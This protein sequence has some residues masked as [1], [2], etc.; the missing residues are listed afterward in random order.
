MARDTPATVAGIKTW[1]RSKNMHVVPIDQ[2]NQRRVDC[3]YHSFVMGLRNRTVWD[4]WKAQRVNLGDFC[5]VEDMREQT[6][7]TLYQIYFGHEEG[8]NP[9]DVHPFRDG[10]LRHVKVCDTC[11]TQG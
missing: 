2:V 8:L 9:N 1:F 10:L 3:F 6:A 7:D 4:V 11:A 5:D